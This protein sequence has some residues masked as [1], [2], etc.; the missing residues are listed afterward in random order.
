[1]LKGSRGGLEPSPKAY[2]IGKNFGWVPPFFRRAL[3]HTGSQPDGC[4][5][6]PSLSS[7]GE[8]GDSPSPESLGIEHDELISPTPMAEMEVETGKDGKVSD[9]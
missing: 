2:K 8:I 7:P 6:H 4:P 9:T 3:P 1:M 5:Q